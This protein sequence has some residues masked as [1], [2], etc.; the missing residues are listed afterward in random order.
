MKDGQNILSKHLLK[1][2]I[3]GLILYSVFNRFYIGGG[4]SSTIFFWYDIM[5]VFNLKI[6]SHS[7]GP[8]ALIIKIEIFL[9][10]SQIIHIIGNI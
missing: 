8:I 7:V 10:K 9:T 3:D 4:S 6:Y 5:I 2:T 1:Y